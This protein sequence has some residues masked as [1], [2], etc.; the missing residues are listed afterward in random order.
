VSLGLSHP[1]SSLILFNFSAYFRFPVQRFA[2]NEKFAANGR[3]AKDDGNPPSPNQVDVIRPKSGARLFQLWRPARYGVFYRS[4][5]LFH[6][7][8]QVW[9]ATPNRCGQGVYCSVIFTRLFL[10][11]FS[12]LIGIVVP[13]GMQ[14]RK[15]LV[16]E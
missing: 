13:D 15:Y 1:S 4:V 9:F 3:A 10:I 12:A 2:E 6:E 8:I 7:E 5:Q 14:G 11:L 16:S